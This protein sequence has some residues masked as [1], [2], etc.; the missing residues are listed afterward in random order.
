MFLKYLTGFILVLLLSC[1]DDD[2]S[3]LLSFDELCTYTP[4]SEI[5]TECEGEFLIHITDKE[6]QMRYSEKLGYYVRFSIQGSYDCEIIGV[7]CQGVYEDSI[8][9]TVRV[10]AD[11]HQYATDA[12]PMVAGVTKVS[13]NRFT[14]K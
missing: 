1:S 2:Q 5:T 4:K 13:L 10:S 3:K 8:G 12:L 14:I 6:A 7:I 11:V 9:S